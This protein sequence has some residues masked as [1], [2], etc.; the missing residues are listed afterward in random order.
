MGDISSFYNI[1]AEQEL[2]GS[3]LMDNNNILEI[4][5]EASDFFKTGHQKL[6]AACKVLYGQDKKIDVTSL[7]ELFKGDLN[8][9]GGVGYIAD[10]LNCSIR[11]DKSKV[12]IIREK[13]R[14]R[15]L[16]KLL[17]EQAQLLAGNKIN[18]DD[19]FNFL[20][21]NVIRICEDSKDELLTDSDLMMKTLNLIEKNALN[22][23]KKIIGLE[24][25]ISDLDV[26]LNGLQNEKLYIIAGRPSMGKSALSTTM[27]QHISKDHHVLHYSIEMGAEELGIRRLA[28]QGFIDTSKLERGLLSEKEWKDVLRTSSLI[29]KQKTFTNTTSGI[30]INDIKRQAAKLHMQGK[31]SLILIDHLGIMSLKGMG[32]SIREQISNIC[33]EL[34]AMAK[35]F[36]IPI[37]LLAQLSRSP[38]TRGDKRPI[39][40]DLKETSGIEEN[41]DVVMLLYREEY[42]NKETSDRGII[43]I[44]IAKQR[45][46]RTGTIK[47]AWAP[48]FQIVASIMKER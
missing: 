37:V 8:D 36:N 41:A 5:L 34:K 1:P 29:G 33:I 14:I 39:L 11:F 12:N 10:L 24:T 32:D 26:A 6:F 16:H 31:L 15:K 46:G 45:S 44:N 4:D 7:A 35:K 27:V 40:A 18:F 21:N 38:E 13:G 48:E 17:T 20:Q 19:S 43:E 23:E 25:G 3:I 30:H 22:P 2:L 9:V 47:L 28:E 42:Y